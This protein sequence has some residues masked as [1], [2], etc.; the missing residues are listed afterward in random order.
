[1]NK[2][3][4]Q[5]KQTADGVL[6][7]LFCIDPCAIVA[8]GAPRDWYLGKEASDIDVFF[9]TRPNPRASVVRKQLERVGFVIIEHK[10]GENIPEN[11]R[12]NPFLVCVFNCSIN[13]FNVQLMLMSESTYTSTLNEFPLS[14]SKVMYKDKHIT[15]TKDFDLSIKHKVLYKTGELYLNGDAYIQKIIKKFPEF[16]YFETKLQALEYI[17]E[18]K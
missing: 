9:Y 16:R 7:A 5:Q 14:L 2:V 11:Y 6:D 4:Q 17:L 8:G 12:R 1:M 18:S 3:I 10:T 13:G 15:T